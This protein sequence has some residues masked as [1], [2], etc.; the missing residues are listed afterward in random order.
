MNS[1]SLWRLLTLMTSRMQWYTI[2]LSNRL[3]WISDLLD[4]DQ[5]VGVEIADVQSLNIGLLTKLK[6]TNQS[7]LYFL[8]KVCS[9]LIEKHLIQ[10]QNAGKCA[11][12]PVSIIYTSFNG[13]SLS[14][15]IQCFSQPIQL[16]FVINRR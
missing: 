7:L 13:N 16:H 12:C 3:N 11:G 15:K 10:I 1:N 9:L 2:S 4:M 14:Y 6:A 8:L 5:R